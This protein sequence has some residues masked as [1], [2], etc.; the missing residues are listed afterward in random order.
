[1][2]GVRCQE[3]VC[4]V[5]GYRFDLNAQ[6]LVAVGLCAHEVAP[7]HR[8]NNIHTPTHIVS[9]VEDWVAS[10]TSDFS[11]PVRLRQAPVRLIPFWVFC[12]EPNFKIKLCTRQHD[13]YMLRWKKDMKRSVYAFHAIPHDGSR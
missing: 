3:F 9:S 10:V 7:P 4:S 2:V 1:M 6:V 5:D 11:H 13:N 12:V 8:I